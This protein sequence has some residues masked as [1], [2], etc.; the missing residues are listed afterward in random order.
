[1]KRGCTSLNEGNTNKK[2]CLAHLGHT[3]CVAQG[4]CQWNDLYRHLE[5]EMNTFGIFLPFAHKNK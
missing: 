1:M 5:T 4:V 3:G 2:R